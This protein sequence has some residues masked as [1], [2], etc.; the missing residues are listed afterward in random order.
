MGTWIVWLVPAALL[1]VAEVMT[2][3]LARP[4]AVAAVVGPL[5]AASVGLPSDR[6]L[7]CRGGGL[8]SARAALA[9]RYIRQPLVLRTGTAALVGRSAIV[10]EEV[11]HFWPGPSAAKC[12]RHAP[13]M[14]RRLPWAS[15]STFRI[16]APALFIPGVPWRNSRA[17]RRC[18]CLAV[19]IFVVKTVRI[20]PQART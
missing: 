18:R 20:V 9:V 7:R 17:R 10:I 19:F 15:P 8:L 5:S 14:G 13:A 11:T 16:R 4:L 1:G 12:G 6:C 2:T 3:T